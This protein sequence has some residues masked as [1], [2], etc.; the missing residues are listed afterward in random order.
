MKGEKDVLR[1]IVKKKKGANEEK[2]MLH[3]TVG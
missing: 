2:K 1:K 3:T